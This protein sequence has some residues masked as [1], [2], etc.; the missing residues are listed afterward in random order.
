MRR[1]LTLCLLITT[2]SCGTPVELDDR[3]ADPEQIQFAA[4]LD[5]DLD[6]MNW[7][8]SGLYWQDLVIGSGAAAAV[9]RHVVS[10]HHIAWLPDG[11]VVENTYEEGAPSRQFPVGGG[12][13]LPGIDEGVIGMQVGGRRKLVVRPELAYGRG[14][15][16]MIPPLTTLVYEVELM[17]LVETD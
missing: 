10:I 1:I 3:W 6:E 17:T 15:N 16:G 4:S 8:A 11:T 14:G 13:A 2:T 9:G 7:T 5:I 12:L